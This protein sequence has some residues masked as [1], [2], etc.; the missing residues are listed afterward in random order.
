MK[1]D[2]AL[3]TYCYQLLVGAPSIR[4]VIA[5]SQTAQEKL[6]IECTWLKFVVVKLCFA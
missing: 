6:L 3:P 5:Y 2:F 4:D 1:H